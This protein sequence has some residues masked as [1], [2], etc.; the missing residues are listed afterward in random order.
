[1]GLLSPMS[2]SKTTFSLRKKISLNVFTEKG[3]RAD[4]RNRIRTNF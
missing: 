3:P 4:E 2:R 1:M